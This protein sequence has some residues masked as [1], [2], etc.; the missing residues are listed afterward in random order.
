MD[1]FWCFISAT[2]LAP[3]QLITGALGH[4]LRPIS[5]GTENCWCLCY[6]LKPLLL[7]LLLF[8]DYNATSATRIYATKSL[9]ASGCL[10]LFNL[11]YS[12]GADFSLSFSDSLNLELV[13]RGSFFIIWRGPV[14][15]FVVIVL[16]SCRRRRCCCLLVSASERELKWRHRDTNFADDKMQNDGPQ[17]ARRPPPGGVSNCKRVRA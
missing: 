12:R 16:L 2:S 8:G 5:E 17:L 9:I 11:I 6:F 15:A 1:T 10:Q 4:T 14:A 7:S 3:L 13:R